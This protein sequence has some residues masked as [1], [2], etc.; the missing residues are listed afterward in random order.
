MGEDC[1]RLGDSHFF[2][3]S[4]IGKSFSAVDK[5]N[6]FPQSKQDDFLPPTNIYCWIT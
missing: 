2:S 1:P 6:I 3:A 5:E 4:N